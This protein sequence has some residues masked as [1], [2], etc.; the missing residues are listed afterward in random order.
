MDQTNLGADGAPSERM[1]ILDM[2][3]QGRISAED[4]LHLLQALNAAEQGDLDEAGAPTASFSQPAALS[5]EQSG[6]PP[7]LASLDLVS[8][9]PI[10]RQPYMPEPAFA[11][12]LPPPSPLTGAAEPPTA[13][14]ASPPSLPDDAQ[15]WKRWWMLPLWIGVAFAV[16]GGLFMALAYQSSGAGFWLVCASLPMILGMLVIVLAWLS[17]SAPW[18]HLRVRQAPG[19]KPER[20]A[21]SMPL[22]VRPAAWFLG[23]FGRWIP[24]IREQSWDEV[25]RAVGE[26]TSPENPLFIQVDEGE[27]GEKVEIYIG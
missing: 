27:F 2:I 3:E 10:T 17:R 12:P 22:P 19:E 18:L 24:D 26:K 7:E 5:L 20:I 13:M 8:A 15:K 14:P 6:G 9:E 21:I 1:L 23:F 4:G 11:E 25:I 16:F